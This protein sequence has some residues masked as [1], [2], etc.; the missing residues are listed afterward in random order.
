MNLLARGMKFR[1]VLT[2][3]DTEATPVVTA[4][5]VTVDMPDRFESD[6]D[7]ASGAGAKVISF[8]PAFKDLQG[9]GIAAQNLSSGDYYVITN[10][11]VSGFT[12]TFYN[13]S[14]VAVDRT[15]DY[16]AKGF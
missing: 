6:N 8:S 15:F 3:T 16:V 13:S 2:T 14:D 1:A 7:L 4:L 11:S 9:L 10:K 5:S 12:I